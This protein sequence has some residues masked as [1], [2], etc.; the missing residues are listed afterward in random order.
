MK[1]Y[2]AK[3]VNGGVNGVC[4]DTLHAFWLWQAQREKVEGNIDEEARGARA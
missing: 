4:L 2:F 1:A 3:V